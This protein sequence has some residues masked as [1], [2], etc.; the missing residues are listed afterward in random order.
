MNSDVVNE[1]SATA[2]TH[3]LIFF[4]SRCWC[5][6]T[7]LAIEHRWLSLFSTKAQKGISTWIERPQSPLSVSFLFWLP[8]NMS[9]TVFQ[10]HAI[11]TSS[12]VTSVAFSADQAVNESWPH[13]AEAQISALPQ[14]A[15]PWPWVI[16][17]ATSTLGAA[18]S[19][20]SKNQATGRQLQ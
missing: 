8:N 19:H 17:T 15:L 11:C 5:Y 18:C 7:V 3:S 16:T 6:K 2:G 13:L 10:P 1:A 14:V 20:L 9:L 12:K 4:I